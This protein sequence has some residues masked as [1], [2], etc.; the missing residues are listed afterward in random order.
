MKRLRTLSTML[1]ALSFAGMMPLT[2]GC[3]ETL[4]PQQAGEPGGVMEFRLKTTVEGITY[5]LT[6]CA[7]A[8]RG[9]VKLVLRPDDRP[10]QSLRTDLPVGNYEIELMSGWVL[11]KIDATG[12]VEVV[13]DVKIISKNPLPFEIQAQKKTGVGFSFEVD[14]TVVEFPIGTVD[15]KVDVKQG[16]GCT[17]LDD[18]DK[19]G[20]PDCHDGCPDDAAKWQAGPCGCGNAELDENGNGITDCLEK[21]S[22][23]EGQNA[24]TDKDGIA[25]CQDN[26]PFIAN[27][28]QADADQDGLGDACPRGTKHTIS[29]KFRHT[30]ALR[31]GAVFCW[32]TTTG[33][34]LGNGEDREI[35]TN[36]VPGKPVGQYRDVV[37]LSVSNAHGCALRRTGAVWC[38]GGGTTG[39]LGHGSDSKE[40]YPV[41]VRNLRDAVAIAV[42]SRFSCVLHQAG[43]VS[44]WGEG[45][46]L[47][48]GSREHSAVPV[49][50]KGLKD[51]VH[52][53][54]GSDQLC[55][56]QQG[57]KTFC[58]G[59]W[60][61][62]MGQEIPLDGSGSDWS[63]EPVLATLLPR[64]VDLEFGESN[65]ACGIRASD[66]Q[67]ICWGGGSRLGNGK[68][69]PSAIPVEVIGVKDA[70]K[71]GMGGRSHSC[72]VVADGTVRCWGAGAL[73]HDAEATGWLGIQLT[74]VTAVN[75]ENATQLALGEAY[76]CAALQNGEYKCWG[77]F[78]YGHLGFKRE[79]GDYRAGIVPGPYVQFPP[80]YEIRK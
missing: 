9:P 40:M 43:T 42:G 30:C 55:A 73:G 16:K 79:F 34:A 74:P 39:E 62:M 61:H 22:S 2:L 7:L 46:N 69:E 23:C 37:S 10:D 29:S 57:G 70:I 24:D 48:Y 6:R 33:A 66:R 19:D 44:C 54:A 4:D 1:V 17:A 11:G 21:D 75:V 3:G 58:W 8:I 56:I 72:A 59:K 13:K 14:G 28:D 80:G 45:E 20:I 60:R 41:Q 67:V 50:V 77:G 49:Q 76:S 31:N 71:V 63:S 51:I 26:C 15:V 47:G 53:A 12:K 65:R 38:W 68:E 25:D 27:E 64:L 32:G 52:I 36:N 5:R 78:Q 35:S 18:R